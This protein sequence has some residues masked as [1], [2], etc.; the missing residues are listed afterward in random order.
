[1]DG[2]YGTGKNLEGIIQPGAIIT[3][4]NAAVGSNYNRCIKQFLAEKINNILQSGSNGITIKQHQSHKI[5]KSTEKVDYRTNNLVF[6]D[7]GGVP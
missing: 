6:F 1:M 5:K 2:K 4:K 3:P 7:L